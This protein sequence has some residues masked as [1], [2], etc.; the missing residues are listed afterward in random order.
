MIK[1]P[2][3]PFI[4][5]EWLKKILFVLCLAWAG[6]AT[7]WAY[8]NKPE[9]ILIGLDEAGT[10]IITSANDPILSKERVKFV[11]EF[12]RGFYNYTAA[13]YSVTISQTGAL[14]SDILWKEQEPAFLKTTEQMKTSPL[15]Q[16]AD[17]LDLRE[18]GEQEFEADIG[19][20]IKSRLTER[21]V[22]YRAVVKIGPRKRSAENPYPMEVTS[23]H[24][25]EVE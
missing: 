21:K 12:L 24:E 10:R 2:L 14:M 5:I 6:T 8:R 17:L 7:V 3:R 16:D 20:R 9:I 18:V 19:L 4:K 11:R 1:L 23:I 25:T 22:K 13:D 15:T